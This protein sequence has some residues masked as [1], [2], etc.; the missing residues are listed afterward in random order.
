MK[1]EIDKQG[2]ATGNYSPNFTTGIPFN[3]KWNASNLPSKFHKW[4]KTKKDFILDVKKQELYNNPIRISEII[5]DLSTIDNL[6]ARNELWFKDA[7]QSTLD[8][9]YEDRKKDLSTRRKTLIDE[10]NTLKV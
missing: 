4:S 5:K 6:A 2:Y 9:T 8:V 10:L 1:F 7:D 3:N